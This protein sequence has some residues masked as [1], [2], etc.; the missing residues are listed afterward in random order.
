MA[1]AFFQSLKD[2]LYKRMLK[3]LKQCY[4]QYK[5]KEVNAMVTLATI[6]AQIFWLWN[7]LIALIILF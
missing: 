5:S 7:V 6:E 3:N 1:F 4:E 2:L